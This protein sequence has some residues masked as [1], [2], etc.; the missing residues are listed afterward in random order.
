MSMAEGTL[1]RW[2]GG[3]IANN[4]QG[5]RLSLYMIKPSKT[6]SWRDGVLTETACFSNAGP[7]S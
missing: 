2:I 1:D 5:F 3:E 7:E 6:R 4:W